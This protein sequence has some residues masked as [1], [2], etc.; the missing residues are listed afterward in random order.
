MSGNDREDG[1]IAAQV[2]DH[3]RV[4]SREHLDG[5]LDEPLPL[6]LLEQYAQP[7]Y[8]DHRDQTLAPDLIP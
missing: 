5:Q 2:A 4:K 3:H 7:E 8:C 1:A 6:R